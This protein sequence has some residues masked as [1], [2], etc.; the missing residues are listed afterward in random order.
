MPTL[1]NVSTN[2]HL[3]KSNAGATRGLRA[4][5]RWATSTL[6]MKTIRFYCD[7]GLLQPKDRSA[8][9]YRFFDEENLA[10]LTIIRALPSMDVS[11]PELVRILEVRRAGVSNCSVL[12]DGI[13]ARMESINRRISDLAVM[14]AE[15]ARLLERWEDCGGASCNIEPTD[16]VVAQRKHMNSI[17]NRKAPRGRR[18]STGCD[19][20][21]LTPRAAG[22]VSVVHA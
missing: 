16:W 6:P 12:K 13:A 14:M 17:P 7:E 2:T 11:I 20:H 15:L 9:G 1:V 5:W 4:A 10:E 21:L 3:L 22:R 8:A 19:G 18:L